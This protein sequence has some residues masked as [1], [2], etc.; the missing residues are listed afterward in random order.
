MGLKKSQ[1]RTSLR[2]TID[3]LAASL[4][5]AGTHVC[6]CYNFTGTP[7]VGQQVLP[8]VIYGYGLKEAIDKAFLKKVRLHSYEN[9]KSEEFVKLVIKNFWEKLRRT[10][11]RGN[12]TE[13]SPLFASTIDELKNE[14]RPAVESALS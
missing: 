4:E 9:P 12:A 5:Q 13:S 7:Y 10:T 3:K 2:L 8:E 14:L 1:S 11:T 6:A